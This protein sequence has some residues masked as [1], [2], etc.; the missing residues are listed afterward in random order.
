MGCG[1]S[2]NEQKKKPR[3]EEKPTKNHDFT[4]Q[5]V[6]NNELNDIHSSSKSKGSNS[7]NI[8]QPQTPNI[9]PY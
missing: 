2:N 8:T 4:P 5:K 9:E 3:V 1:L 6:N 7:V